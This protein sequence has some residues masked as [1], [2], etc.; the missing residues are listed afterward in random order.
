[1]TERAFDVLGVG[2]NSLDHVCT[3]DGLPAFAGKA[4]MQGYARLPGGQV[5]TA[6]L[7]C[8]RLGLRTRYVGRVGDDEA[9]AVVLAPLR[10]AG[11]DVDAVQRVPG[12]ST[13][14]AVILVDRASG[15]RTVLWYRDPRLRLQPEDVPAGLVE[16]ARLLHL[17]GGDPESTAR[18]AERARRA[19]IPVLLDADA[20][21][22]GIEK[23]L[24]H[25]DFPIV[26]RGFAET[27]SGTGSVRDGLDR[28]LGLGARLAVV[29][30]G[31][32]GA[33]ARDGRSEIESAGF[34]VTPRDTTGAGDVFH[35]AFAWAL[36]RGLD[37]ERMLRMANAA[38]ALACLAPGAQ[39]G[40]PTRSELEA[41]LAR[42]EPGPWRDPDAPRRKP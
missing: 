31:A 25:V 11:V 22:A 40:L 14:L 13:Q 37:A 6:L 17:D 2:Q 28:L 38:A 30:L 42:H 12:A 21:G 34:R 35:A 23:L 16:A 33:L 18:A 1:M 36:L 7:A 3:L 39:G 27:F 20:P 26:S 19:G 24:A 32:D 4:A 10:A 29:T 9:A 15:E 41:F 8:T 5:A